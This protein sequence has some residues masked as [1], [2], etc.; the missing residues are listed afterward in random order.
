MRISIRRAAIG[1]S[2]CL[3]AAAAGAAAAQAP[4]VG[5]LAP[6]FELQGSDGNTYRLADF[7]G[8][9]AVVIAW[10]PKAFT[11]GCTIECKSLAENGH[12]IRE[13]D[14]T[15]FM[16]SVDSVEVNAGFAAEQNAD[17]PL[18]SDPTK[19]VA[20]A[21]GV[22]GGAGFAKRHTFYI[23]ADGRILAVDRNVRPATSAEDMAATL[24]ELGVAR[25]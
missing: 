13:Y 9:Q 6:A 17:F 16:A 18:L 15:Y 8:R 19:A 1:I 2:V 14:V 23:G 20:R 4:D 11:S 5:D 22:L 12:L 25:R 10:F 21:Y 24:G 3:A 7:S